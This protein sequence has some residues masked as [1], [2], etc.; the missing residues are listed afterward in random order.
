MLAA[1]KRAWQTWR[2]VL[3]REDAR[4]RAQLGERSDEPDTKPSCEPP[5]TP[6]LSDLVEKRQSELKRQ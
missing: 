2:H 3:D 1:V 5:R 4:W 6:T